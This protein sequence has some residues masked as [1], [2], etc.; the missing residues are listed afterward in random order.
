M[1][2]KQNTKLLALITATALFLLANCK[3]STDN[4][5]EQNEYDTDESLDEEVSA[6]DATT[7]C[8]AM[9]QG[10]SGSNVTGS[11]TF[12]EVG[13][14][15]VQI[16]LS[17]SNAEPGSHAVHLHENGDCSASDATSAGGHWNPT[18]TKHGKR[19][20]GEFH[21]GDIANMT[22]DSV[23]N[24]S[25]EMTVQG[26]TIGGEAASDILNKAVIIHSGADDFT[27][28]PSGNAGSRVACGVIEMK[29]SE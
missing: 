19:G 12:T 23:G 16:R 1:N 15:S 14:A 24:G 10:A 13:D 2:K 11:A 22:V 29:Q 27:S 3:G 6:T 26:W 7:E 25:L 4:Q 18:D 5:Q 17:I 8:V 21:K 20:S 28:Q 9:L